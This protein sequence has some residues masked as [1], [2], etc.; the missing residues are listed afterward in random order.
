MVGLPEGLVDSE[1]YG[2]VEPETF[3]TPVA[4]RPLSNPSAMLAWELRVGR[5]PAGG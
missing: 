5:S 4:L 2:S 1:S 3:F